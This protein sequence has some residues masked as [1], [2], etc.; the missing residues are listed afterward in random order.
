[1]LLNARQ[2]KCLWHNLA[3]LLFVGEGFGELLEDSSSSDRIS[4]SS[5]TMGFFP[6]SRAVGCFSCSL[7]CT[8]P[9]PKLCLSS[10]WAEDDRFHAASVQ[11][12]PVIPSSALLVPP[13]SSLY[14]DAS[15]RI[16]LRGTES[17]DC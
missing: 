7:S 13:A 2:C 10:T 15:A 5:R 11:R 17:P 16:S 14:L 1:M 6:L 9:S 3:L 8:S 4:A 12:D